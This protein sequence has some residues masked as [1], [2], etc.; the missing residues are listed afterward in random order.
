[1]N[2]VVFGATG[3][4]GKEVLKQALAAGH[5]VSAL[6]RDPARLPVEL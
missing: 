6:V 3:G 4:T 1:M 2:I 5:A